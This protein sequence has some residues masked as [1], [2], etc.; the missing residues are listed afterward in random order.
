VQDDQVLEME[1]SRYLLA[2]AGRKSLLANNG[3]SASLLSN[4]LAK[5]RRKNQIKNEITD[6]EMNFE[7]FHRQ[8]Q[9]F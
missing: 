8:N 7:Y 5:F 3:G 4:R 2:H 1:P 6:S 9:G